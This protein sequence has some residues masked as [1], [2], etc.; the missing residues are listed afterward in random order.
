MG[1]RLPAGWDWQTKALALNISSAVLS[2]FLFCFCFRLDRVSALTCAVF[3]PQRH[4]FE[5]VRTQQ[6][7]SGVEQYDWSRSRLRLTPR[8]ACSRKRAEPESSQ[9]RQVS[10]ETQTKS[11]QRTVALLVIL[12]RR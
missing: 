12:F 3:N 9:R 4:S 10:D 2:F 6:S 5:Q 7:H 11:R 8:N 1:P